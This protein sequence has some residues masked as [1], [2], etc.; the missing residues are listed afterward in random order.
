MVTINIEVPEDLIILATK[1]EKITRAEFL[2]ELQAIYQTM[3]N[4]F[5]EI[6]RFRK[7]TGVNPNLDSVVDQIRRESGL[8]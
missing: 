6:W 4:K 2:H 3:V 8:S 5:A 7:A 1:E